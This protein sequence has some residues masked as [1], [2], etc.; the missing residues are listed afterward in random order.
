MSEKIKIDVD[1]TEKILSRLQDAASQASHFEEKYPEDDSLVKIFEDVKAAMNDFK[2]YTSNN[3]SSDVEIGKRFYE[4]IDDEYGKGTFNV[5]LKTWAAN[6]LPNN[7]YDLSNLN[8]F[9]GV[10]MAKQSLENIIAKLSKASP[11]DK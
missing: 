9:E 5:D 3:E 6:V 11:D 1:V 8:H 7:D 2:E 4:R 10:S